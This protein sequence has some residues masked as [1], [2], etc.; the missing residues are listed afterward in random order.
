MFS[1]DLLS[2]CAERVFAGIDGIQDQEVDPKVPFPASHSAY[3][4][5]DKVYQLIRDNWPRG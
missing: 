4:H 5:D 2:F 3:W 1:Q